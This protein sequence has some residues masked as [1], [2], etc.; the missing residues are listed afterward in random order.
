MVLITRRAEFS[1]SH[2]CAN[3]EW[4][5]ERNEQVYGKESRPD[6]HGHNY[7]LDVTLAGEPDPL[8]GMVM[9]LKELKEIIN[10]EV[11]EVY[12]HRFLNREVE[13][14]DRVTPTPENVV[15]Q[16]WLRLEPALRGETR[17]LHS[18][19]LY[20]TADLYVD[21]FGEEAPAGR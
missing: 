11:V 6:G 20:Q 9:D 4:S 19:R 2:F 18:I 16:I 12:D 5:A 7:V 1:A 17:R 14:F 13:P 21:Y 3:P 15:T 10:R 8:N